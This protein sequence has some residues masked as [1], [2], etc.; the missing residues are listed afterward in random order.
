MPSSTLRLLLLKFRLMLLRRPRI[1]RVWRQLLCCRVPL[2]MQPQCR[3]LRERP[4]P[5]PPVQSCPVSGATRV[6]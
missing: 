5:P 4:Y 1:T 6:L 2:G 3:H